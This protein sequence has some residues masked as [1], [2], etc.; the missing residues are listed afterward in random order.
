MPAPR[1]RL[2]VA[3]DLPSIGDADAML[4]GLQGRFIKHVR[5]IRSVLGM[6]EGI[7]DVS[8]LS[9]LIMPFGGCAL[10]HEVVADIRLHRPLRSRP[11]ETPAPSILR[12]FVT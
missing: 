9:M 10:D 4:C 1:D 5:D 2:I 8:A 12:A 7:K 6:Q 3:L 11:G